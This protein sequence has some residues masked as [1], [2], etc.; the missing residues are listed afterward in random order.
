MTFKHVKFQD[1]P[2]MRALEKF[3]KDKGLIKPEPLQKSAALAKRADLTPSDNLMD[4][5]FKLCAGMR[6]QGLEK[7]AAEVET[8]YLNYKRAQTLYEAHKEKGED[9]IQFAHPKGSHKLE[10][11]EGDE[12]VVEDILDKHVKFLQMIEKK[13]TGKLSNASQVLN[14]VKVALGDDF[15]DQKRNKKSLGQVNVDSLYE[16][17]KVNLQKYRQVYGSMSTKTGDGIDSN[18]SYFN[19][20]LYILDNKKVYQARDFENSLV[21]SLANFQSDKEPGFFS[22]AQERQLW[23]DEILPMVGIANRYAIAFQENVKDIRKAETEAKS[24]AVEQQFDPDAKPAEPTPAAPTSVQKWKTQ[25]KTTG[26]TLQQWLMQTQNDP[27][28]NDS[29]KASAKDWINKQ[30]STIQNLDSQVTDDNAAI[31]ALNILKKMTPEFAQFRKEW[32]G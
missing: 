17:A 8:N 30:I 3:A 5:I 24:K 23:N 28:N 20:L 9:V 22:N 32:I 13:P 27:E 18:N 25:L 12:A 2:T 14:A 11:V 21:N 7:E 26:D 19:S 16:Q 10:G 15:L 29:D 31:A 4:N 1:S 6:A